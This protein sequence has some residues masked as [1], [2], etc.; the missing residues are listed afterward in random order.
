MRALEPPLAALATSVNVPVEQNWNTMLQNIDN[1]VKQLKNQPRTPQRD[2][3][4]DMLR[5]ASLYFDHIRALYRNNTQHARLRYNREDALSVL[6]LV[7][8]FMVHLQKTG[9]HE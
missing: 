2:Q 7:G 1:A 6:N 9:L 3:E 5:G 8:G 4:L